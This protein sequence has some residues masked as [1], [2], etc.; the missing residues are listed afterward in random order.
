MPRF[1]DPSGLETYGIGICDRC[2]RKLPLGELF[3]DP[4]TPGLKVCRDDLDQYDPYRL[5]AR[6]TENIA[7]R[8]TRPDFDL[9]QEGSNPN[10]DSLF[11]LRTT[12]LGIRGTTGGNRR[13]T[14][15][16]LP[17]DITTE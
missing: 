12:Q 6:R 17:P 9:T 11:G 5:P 15:P 3:S 14:T 10:A 16:A 8:F 4:N 13:I 2:S 7:L 1:I